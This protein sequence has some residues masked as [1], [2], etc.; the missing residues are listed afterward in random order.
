MEMK[1][2]LAVLFLFT[3]ILVL[4]L[5]GCNSTYQITTSVSGKGTIT[6]DKTSVSG[7]DEALVKIQADDGYFLKDFTA[8]GKYISPKN[9]EYVLKNLKEDTEIKA[10]FAKVETYTEE[11]VAPSTVALTFYDQDAA[12]YGVT[13][14]NSLGG[15]PIIEYMKADGQTK[16]DAD[17]TKADVIT[18]Q[19]LYA[20]DEYKNFGTLYD[21]E[22]DTEYLYRVGDMNGVYSE[23]FSFKT[24]QENPEA[25]TFIHTSDSQ[26]DVNFGTLWRLALDDAFNKYKDSEFVVTTG[27]IVQHGG[28]S[29]EW[30]KMLGNVSPYVAERPL[31]PVAGNH[32]YWSDYL[33]GKT[34]VT[35]S[36][37]FMD[38]PEQDTTNGMFYSFDYGNAHFVVLN[39]GDSEVTPGG[40]TDEQLNWLKEDLKKSKQTWK[41][42]AMHN[43]LYSPGKYGSDP[44]R[45]KEAL[46]LQD[47]LNELL[48]DRDVDLVLTGHDHMYSRTYP[49]SAKGEPITDTKTEKADFNG[50]QVE[51]LVNPEGPV[52]LA[53]GCSGNQGRWTLE[54]LDEKYAKMFQEKEDMDSDFVSYSAITIDGNRL[55]VNYYMVTIATEEAELISSWGI[56]K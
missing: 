52:H 17:F 45:N 50:T 21:L 1:K 39:T 47:Q 4:C 18:A 32:D 41:I 7:K 23:V 19:S 13:W 16:E 40:L 44:D 14:H 49:V 56:Q 10:Y 31:I 15:Q 51:Y 22:F 36:H 2:K 33:Y 27:D 11:Q 24:R 42:I 43:P 54:G 28:S 55:T 29:S 8:N 53:S 30:R 12:E 37:F 9:G 34:G 26:D 38:L 46:C 5:V 35:Y 20:G 48:V 3:S 6:V 25:F